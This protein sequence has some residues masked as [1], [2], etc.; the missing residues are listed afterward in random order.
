MQKSLKSGKMQTVKN[1]YEIPLEVDI[2]PFFFFFFLNLF[3]YVSS[4]FLPFF[5][6]F[7]LF[8]IFQAVDIFV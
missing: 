4:F 3:Y 1:W 6:Y 7:I 2:L 8:G 5:L